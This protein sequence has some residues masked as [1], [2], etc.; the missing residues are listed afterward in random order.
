MAIN[1]NMIKGYALGSVM[2]KFV[3][4]T[5][6]D[7]LVVEHLRHGTNLTNYI[8]IR[9]QGARVDRGGKTTGSTHN[10]VQDDTR[11]KFYCFKD[12]DFKEYGSSNSGIF[13]VIYYG[14]LKCFSPK[15]HMHLSRS[16]LFDEIGFNKIVS[17]ILS[18]PFLL[19]TP[20]L[21]FAFTSDEIKNPAF[22]FQNDPC[23]GGLA[24]YTTKNVNP[25]R[26]GLLGSVWAG[27]NTGIFKRIANNPKV[28]LCGVAELGLTVGLGV[29]SA[30]VLIKNPDTMIPMAVGFILG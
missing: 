8:S 1:T 21:K 28:F 23:Y 27:L 24:Y 12:Y 13:S 15:R 7:V 3:D 29:L 2:Y 22:A 20:T 16:N 10:N 19:V 17:H 26:I 14:A 25:V 18:I 6:K 5:L 4:Y 9:L 30:R 11:G